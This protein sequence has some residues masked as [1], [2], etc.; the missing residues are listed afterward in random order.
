MNDLVEIS[1]KILSDCL[2]AKPG[3]KYLVVTDDYEEELANYLYKAGKELGLV[4]MLFKILPLSRSGEEPPLAV[5]EAMK[6]VDVAICITQKSLTHTKAK[7]EAAKSGARIA[8]MPGITKDMFLKGAITA[9][10]AEVERLTKKV[11]EILTNGKHVLIEKDGHKLE[12]SIEGRMGIESTGRYL[13]KGQSG[14]LPSGE[15]YIAPVEGSSRGSILADGSIVGLG[16]LAS[17]IL[18]RIERGLLVDATGECA[19]EWLK[20]LGNSE[21]A[22]NVAEFGIGTNPNARLTGNILEDEKIL[23]TIHVAFGSNSDFGGKVNAGIHL[24]AVV[25]A[26]TFYVDGRLIMDKGKL[27][28]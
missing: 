24:D 5:A 12:M 2:G 20:I 4:S 13:E 1:K 6:N 22:R 8:T 10:Y 26:P 25:L 7:E 14:N 19:E 15:A 11:A 3:E 18:L 9:D 17:P 23:G 28:V 16:K 21:A 27:L